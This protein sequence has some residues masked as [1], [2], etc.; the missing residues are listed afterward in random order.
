MEV[1][2]IYPELQSLGA[3]VLVVSFTPPRRVA[4][5]LEV[6]PQTFPVVSDPTLAAYHAFALERV[7]VRSLFRLDVIARF[8]GLIFRGWMPKTPTRGDDVLQLGGDFIL[9]A[10]GTLRYAHP[11]AEPTDRPSGSELV[12]AIKTSLGAWPRGK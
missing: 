10:A 2:R 8:V 7:P 4:A 6:Y 3:E 11:S 5:Y 9:D 12:E 1:Q